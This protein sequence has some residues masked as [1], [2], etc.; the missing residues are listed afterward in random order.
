VAGP[1]R[2]ARVAAR[3]SGT[4]PDPPRGAPG[5]GEHNAEILAELGYDDAGVAALAE[6]GV[7][8]TKHAPTSRVPA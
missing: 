3:F 2:Q 8:G 4:V 1:L 5:L 6:R 7:I